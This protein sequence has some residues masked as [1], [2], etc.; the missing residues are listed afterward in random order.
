MTTDIRTSY[1]TLLRL[2]GPWEI[3]DVEVRQPPGD[4][5]APGGAAR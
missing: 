3:T 2:K 5:H 1:A 4:V